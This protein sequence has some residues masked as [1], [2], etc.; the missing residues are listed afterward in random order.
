LGRTPSST[1]PCGGAPLG[2]A[3]ADEDATVIVTVDKTV[4]VGVIDAMT[5]ERPLAVHGEQREEASRRAAAASK[6]LVVAAISGRMGI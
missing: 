6:L 4:K 1:P 2:V 5:A 3:D